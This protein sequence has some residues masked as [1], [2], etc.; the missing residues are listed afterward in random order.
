MTTPPN[1]LPFD[2]ERA[3]SGAKV[4]TRDLVAYKLWGVVQGKHDYPLVGTIEKDA[5]EYLLRSAIDG[6]YILDADG[7]GFDLFIL[8][9]TRLV[10]WT[11]ED[12]PLGAWYCASNSIESGA[13]QS[14]MISREGIFYISYGGIF[15]FVNYAQLA[16]KFKH[17]TESLAGPWKPCGREVQG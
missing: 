8:P 12:V 16:D 2:L 10:P 15:C 17:T 1:L 6:K 14:I 5:G 3:K 9:E 4:V 13:F 7:H 11:M